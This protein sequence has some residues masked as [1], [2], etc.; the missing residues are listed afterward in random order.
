MGLCGAWVTGRGWLT[1]AE[2]C[3]REAG[4]VVSSPGAHPQGSGG[5]GGGGAFSAFSLAV[6][7]GVKLGQ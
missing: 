5:G 6:A 7:T 3:P 1:R 4:C 2:L